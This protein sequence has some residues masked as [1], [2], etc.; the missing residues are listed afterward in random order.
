MIWSVPTNRASVVAFPSHLEPFGLVPLEA[1]ACGTPVV[2]VAEAGIRETVENGKTG[3]LTERS[4]AD[5]GRAI[6]LLLGDEALRARMGNAG[7]RHVEECWTWDQSFAMLDENLQ[8]VAQHG[9]P[10][11][12]PGA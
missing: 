9:R 7:R 5:F 4:P 3:F 12:T 8:R 6:E 11:L 1:M 2:G 10:G